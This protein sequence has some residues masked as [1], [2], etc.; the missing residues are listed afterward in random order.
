M[1]KEQ[2]IARFERELDFL[3]RE[4]YQINSYDLLHK[5]L[6][7]KRTEPEFLKAMNKAPLF[8]GFTITSYQHMVIMGLAKIFEKRNGDGINIFRFLEHI[9]N[10]S[11]L[12]FDIPTK[13]HQ[14]I[15]DKNLITQHKEEL[16]KHSLLIDHIL[17]WRDKSFAHFDKKYNG[18]NSKKVGQDFPIY[19]HEIGELINLLGYILN[20]YQSAYKDTV[21]HLIPV[22]TYDVDNVLLALL[23]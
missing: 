11:L 9:E 18:E 13:E 23:K 20:T 2:V 10:H 12:I 5:H 8:F 6:N 7:N 17:A 22:D 21:T 15:V 19:N 4:L 3:I 1:M 14:P 16:N